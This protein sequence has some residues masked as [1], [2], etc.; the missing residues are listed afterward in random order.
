MGPEIFFL[1]SRVCAINGDST[2]VNLLRDVKAGSSPEVIVV[3]QTGLE[4][5]AVKIH[6]L[7][8]RRLHTK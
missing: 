6:A 4:P 8:Y 2:H 7:V 5:Y 1:S 3:I